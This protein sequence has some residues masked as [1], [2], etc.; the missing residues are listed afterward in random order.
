MLQQK[1]Y[2][3]TTISANIFIFLFS[4]LFIFILASTIFAF[5]KTARK[6]QKQVQEKRK[7]EMDT[8]YIS[9]QQISIFSWR[10]SFLK[11]SCV[12]FLFAFC[13]RIL[14]TAIGFFDLWI[15][16]RGFSEILLIPTTYYNLMSSYKF[17]IFALVAVISHLAFK[18]ILKRRITLLKK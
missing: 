16:E 3:I 18:L 12:I 1:S 9:L 10:L 2:I 7:N 4:L 5:I 13:L 8:G 14:V 11:S 6:F 17:I 15:F